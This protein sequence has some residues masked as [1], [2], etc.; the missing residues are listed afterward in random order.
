MQQ[1]LNK[2]QLLLNFYHI[3]TVNNK[4]VQFPVDFDCKIKVTES[5]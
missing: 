1:K 5:H 3:A 4:L 2:S